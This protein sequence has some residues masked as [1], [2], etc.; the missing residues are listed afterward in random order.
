MANA[1]AGS[2]SI[3]KKPSPSIYGDL[4]TEHKNR[5]EDVVFIRGV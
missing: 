3:Q 5:A 2:L 4:K 1:G